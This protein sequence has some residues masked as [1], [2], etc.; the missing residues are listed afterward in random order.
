M[1]KIES[2]IYKEIEANYD[3]TPFTLDD[4]DESWASFDRKIMERLEEKF[5]NEIQDITQSSESAIYDA[6]DN[7]IIDESFRDT[8]LEY[9]HRF[10]RREWDNL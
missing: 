6:F 5:R 4:T 1:A 7:K 10:G 3:N 9:I 8:F 2:W